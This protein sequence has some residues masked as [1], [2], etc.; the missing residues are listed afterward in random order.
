MNYIFF[1]L[2]TSGSNTS[3]D[4][5]LEAFF[6]L[7]NDSFQELDRLSLRCRLK[8]GVIPNL[9]A[10]LINRSTVNLLKN[11]NMSWYQ[12][13]N[14]IE[15]KLRQWS[16]AYIWGYG[17]VNFDFEFLRKTWWKSLKEP[18]LTNT[19]GN[20][21]GDIL[22]V[23]RAAK[24]VK[25]DI[26]KTPI[27]PKGNP[28]FKLAQLMKHGDAHGA[29][30]DTI[31]CKKLAE[32]IA[33]KA[34]SIWRS[35]LMTASRADTDTLI[36]NEKMFCNLEY[37]YGKLR[38]FLCHFLM[39]H[40]VYKWGIAWDMQWAPED[41]IKMDKKTLKEAMSK[42]PKIYRLIR[43]NKAPVILNANYGLEK[44][45][46]SKISPEILNKRIL[47]LDKSTEFKNRISDILKEIA[48][49]K[50][51]KKVDPLTLHPEDRLHNLYN[52]EFTPPVEKQKMQQFHSVDWK[53][54]I[55]L[56]DKFKEDHNNIFARRLVYEEAGHLLPKSIFNEVK[57]TI[58]EKILNPKNDKVNW[59]TVAD[60]YQQ[61][62]LERSKSENDPKKMKLLE[63]YNNFVM[64]IE[65]KY[66]NA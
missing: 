40:P 47:L 25:D 36:K 4:S 45:P 43:S 16:P 8:E 15:A 60:F 2:E 26:I 30:A 49:E 33:K 41:F 31:Q 32:L 10:V 13:V 65:K 3:H 21:Q 44:E 18:Y 59:T 11:S 62:D 64:D 63:E 27:S 12:L 52:F 28:V 6:M 58:A 39:L 23:I 29:E 9:N 5:I 22:H 42:S 19:G 51:K 50:T 34:N 1:D 46:Y 38:I 35:S 66:E 56:M 55:N 20:K 53:E 7:T 48:E 24:L 14:A 37:F 54:K 57:R 17:S 61:I